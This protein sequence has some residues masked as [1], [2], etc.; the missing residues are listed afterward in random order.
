MLNTLIEMIT[1]KRNT[2]T[3]THIYIYLLIYYL[4]AIHGN[5]EKEKETR[6]NSE[7]TISRITARGRKKKIIGRKKKRKGQHRHTS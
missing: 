6:Q 7:K 4:P 1:E 3:H 5:K 2:H